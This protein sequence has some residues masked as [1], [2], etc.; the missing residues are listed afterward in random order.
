MGKE[1]LL[2]NQLKMRQWKK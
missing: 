1:L 2:T